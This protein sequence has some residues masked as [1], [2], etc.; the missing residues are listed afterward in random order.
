MEAGNIIRN[1]G[2]VVSLCDDG[3]R[4]V[5]T[6]VD[7]IRSYCLNGTWNPTITCEPGT[8]C[9]NAEYVYFTM[10]FGQFLKNL[11]TI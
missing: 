10:G 6:Q 7:E 5:D 1:N 11:F 3:Y 8:I 4:S 9:K 2:A